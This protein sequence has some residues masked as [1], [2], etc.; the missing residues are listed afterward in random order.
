MINVMKLSK[1]AVLT[2]L[3]GMLLFGLVGFRITATVFAIAGIPIFNALRYF[4]RLV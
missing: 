3:I 1:G 2:A 4:R